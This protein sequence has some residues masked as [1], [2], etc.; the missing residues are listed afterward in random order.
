MSAPAIRAERLDG[1]REEEVIA[2]R[3]SPPQNPALNETAFLD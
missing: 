1:E 3:M 2:E